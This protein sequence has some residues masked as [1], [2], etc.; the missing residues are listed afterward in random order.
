MVECE[1][2]E[3]AY[4]IH[5][6]PCVSRSACPTCGSLAVVKHGTDAQTIRDLPC[7]GKQVIIEVERIRYR[8]KACRKTWFEVFPHIDEHRSATTRL[9]EYVQMHSLTRTFVAIAAECGL[10]EKTVRNIFQEYIQELERTTHLV[11]PVVMGIDEVH[12]LGQPRGIITDVGARKIVEMLPERKKQTI[13]RYFTTLPDKKRVQV[14]VIDMWRPYLDVLHDQL[15][16]V[17]VVIDKFHVLRMLSQA[18]EATRKEIRATLSD[19]QRRT[20][21]HD[22][23]L[24]LRRKHDLSEADLLI[25]ESWLGAFPR[26]QAV[27]ECKEAFYTIY[28]ALTYEDALERYTDWV[29]RVEQCDVIHVFAEVLRAVENW[30][31]PI[32]AYFQHRYTGSYVEGANSLI[33]SVDRA[34]RGYS[35][36]V[37]RARMLYGQHLLRQTRRRPLQADVQ[38]EN[39]HD[40]LGMGNDLVIATVDNLSTLDVD[41]KQA[42]HTN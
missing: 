42:I 39:E 37:L 32:F 11:T 16:G 8:C 19:S 41:A 30:K 36:P 20:L 1:E 7:H 27:Y 35:F 33:R 12:L 15:P 2:R 26:L 13:A 6:S 5:A 17:Q 9:I 10:D 3:R 23:F 24:L 38:E 31:E 40:S 25:L 28:D 4:I 21:M 18:V 22:R 29:E 34:G 14:C